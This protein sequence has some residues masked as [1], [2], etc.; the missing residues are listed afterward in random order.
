MGRAGLF[1][2]AQSVRAGGC[3]EYYCVLLYF[4]TGPFGS[5]AEKKPAARPDRRQFL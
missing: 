3:S 5:D 2:P 4:R 1:F